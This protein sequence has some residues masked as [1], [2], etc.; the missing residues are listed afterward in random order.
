MQR[1]EL[2]TLEVTGLTQRGDGVARHAGFAVFVPGAIP[3]ETVRARVTEVRNSFARATLQEIVHPSPAREV[4]PCAIAGV[5]GGCALQ[6]LSAT[7]QLQWK[8]QFVVDAL[9]RIGK[10]DANDVEAR[11]APTVDLGDCWNYRD[12]V[13]YRVKLEAGRWIGGFVCAGSHDIV[14]APACLIARPVHSLL[15]ACV[16]TGV[17]EA[18]QHDRSTLD[19]L[20]KVVIRIHDDGALV[21]LVAGETGDGSGA[22]MRL[23]ARVV[24]LANTAHV[25]VTGIALVPLL[26]VEKTRGVQ[27]KVHGAAST[28]AGDEDDTGLLETLWGTTALAYDVLGVRLQVSATAFAQVNRTAAAAIYG[29]ARS[30]A[31][32]QSGDIVFDLYCGVGALAILSAGQGRVVYGIESNRSA[33]ADARANSERAGSRDVAWLCALAEEEMPRLQAAG[34]RPDV[35]LLDPP[36]AGCDRRVIDAIQAARPRRVV[37][38]SCDPAT[39]ARDIRILAEGGYEFVE[40]IPIDAFP[41]TGH[42]ECV[43]S[44]VKMT[45]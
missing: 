14:A 26:D 40:A 20:A 8:R 13:T 2:L 9:I 10:L 19:T 35:V 1:Y 36:R 44:L 31:G 29:R 18:D 33:I 37:Y 43:V 17:E 30:A 32:L 7:L 39:L 21:M 27:S 41:Q 6:H 34:I 25:A 24:A 42:V 15:L 12:K 5:C 45:E 38:V 22:W 23:A 3:G 16:L 28:D 4:P 11:V